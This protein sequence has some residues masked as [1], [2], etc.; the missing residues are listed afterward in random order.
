MRREGK[1]KAVTD[2]IRPYLEQ[3]ELDTEPVPAT[4]ALG[5]LAERVGIAAIEPPAGG[6]GVRAELRT[7]PRAARPSGGEAATRAPATVGAP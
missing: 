6:G 3:V 4:L 1:G 7:Q 2:D 5:P